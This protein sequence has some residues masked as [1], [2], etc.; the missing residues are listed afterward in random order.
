[1]KRNASII[2]SALSLLL[3]LG[4]SNQKPGEQQAGLSL[5]GQTQ[6]LNRFEQEIISYEAADKIKSPPQGAVLF[7]G[8]SSIRL[9][10]T[11]QQDFP[12]FSVINR[13]FGGSTLP[14]VAWYAPRI[15]YK[16]K[17]A[18][19]ILYCGENDM[20]EDIPP[21]VAFQRFKKLVADMEEHLP[22][23]PLLALSAKPSPARWHLWGQFQQYNIL[24]EEFAHNHAGITYVDVSPPLLKPDGRPDPSLYAEDQLHLNRKGYQKWTALLTPLIAAQLG[25]EES[26]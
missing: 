9:W 12:S 3:A 21:P 24:V 10:N 17:P 4:C 15:I 1:M 22:G 20:A 18:L 5:R 2:L 16:Y 6:P 25:L 8:S 19:V 11:L 23:V 7:A 26:R 13:G 14:E